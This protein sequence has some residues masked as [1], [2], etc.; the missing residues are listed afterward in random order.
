MV[1][2]GFRVNVRPASHVGWHLFCFGT[3][4]PGLRRLMREHVGEGA[5][6]LEIGANIGWHSL[7]LARLAGTTGAVHA[8]EPNPS[9]FQ[10]LRTHLDR[11]RVTNTTAWELALSDR[12][13]RAGFAAPDAGSHGAGDGHLATAGGGRSRWKWKPWTGFSKICLAWTSS[14]SMWKAGSLRF[15][16]EAWRFSGGTVR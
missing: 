11:N 6:C 1:L 13:G 2:E 5:V 14:R 16:R 4:E 8:F 3:Y 12:P 9:V 10:E 7:L 15:G